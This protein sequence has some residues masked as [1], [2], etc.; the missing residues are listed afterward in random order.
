MEMR[1][2]EAVKSCSFIRTDRQYVLDNE[3]QEND[4]DV[5]IVCVCA[6]LNGVLLQFRK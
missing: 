3:R 4:S 6:E 2:V 1:V 5:V